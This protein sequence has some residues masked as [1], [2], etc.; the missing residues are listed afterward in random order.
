MNQAREVIKEVFG[1]D[2]EKA[3]NYCDMTLHHK[4]AEHPLVIT[5]GA[6]SGKTVLMKLIKK[7]FDDEDNPIIEDYLATGLGIIESAKKSKIV[8]IDGYKLSDLRVSR[9]L[10]ITNG[11]PVLLIPTSIENYAPSSNF[12]INL[13]TQNHSSDSKK[14]IMQALGE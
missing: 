3:L 10:E 2:G 6:G 5:G 9:I 11:K 13:S 14:K 7:A 8:M 12:F 1:K 4:K